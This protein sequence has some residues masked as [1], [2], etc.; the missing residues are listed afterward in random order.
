MDRS[1]PM[2][3]Q[4]RAVH[5]A[6]HAVAAYLEGVRVQKV[7]IE[8]EALPGGEGGGIW[9]RPPEEWTEEHLH[10]LALWTW[11]GTVAESVLLGDSI[12][13]GYA[14][15][16][17]KLHDLTSE[18]GAAPASHYLK[19]YLKDAARQ[20]IEDNQE[21]VEALSNRLLNQPTMEGED[22]ERFLDVRTE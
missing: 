11:A 2:D 17:R 21:L 15:D 12:Q 22:V 18:H 19:I 9:L 20:T 16:L 13:G 10:S 4:H 1:L 3:R 7:S 6:G 14:R 5:E 8:P